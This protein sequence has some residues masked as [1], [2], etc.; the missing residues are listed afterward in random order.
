MSLNIGKGDRTLTLQISKAK[1]GPWLFVAGF[2]PLPGAGLGASISAYHTDTML[3]VDLPLLEINK[4]PTQTNPIHTPLND[5]NRSA[6]DPKA[7]YCH[8]R[9]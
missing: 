9:E 7:M 4:N 1:D 6:P 5:L 2:P 3:T 8:P